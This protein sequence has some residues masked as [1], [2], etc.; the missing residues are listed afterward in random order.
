MRIEKSVP[1]SKGPSGQFR[2]DVWVDQ[3]AIPHEA[4]Q[5]MTVVLVRFAPGAR[6]A[7]HSHP[8]GQ[9][10]HVTAGVARFG[11]RDGATVE[12]HAGQTLYT[13]PGEEHWHGALP[14]HFMTHL[15]MWEDDDATWG[16]HVTDDEYDA[17][18]SQQS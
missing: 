3:I 2:G 9:Y 12:L 14:D 5:R 16:A 6:T 15:A 4:E 10:L 1:S 7:W 8:R 13:P 11:T 18:A 17:A